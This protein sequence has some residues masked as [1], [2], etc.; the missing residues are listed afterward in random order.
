MFTHQ[1]L[2]LF[3]NQRNIKIINITATR[4]TTIYKIGPRNVA[5]CLL[6]T[7]NWRKYQ[8]R[9]KMLLIKQA[10]LQFSKIQIFALVYVNMQLQFFDQKTI[11]HQNC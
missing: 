10:R 11:G 6:T 7:K 9:F 3:Y 2:I 1:C 4:L 5:I 8:K